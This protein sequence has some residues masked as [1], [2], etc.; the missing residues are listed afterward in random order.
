MSTAR[1]RARVATALAGLLVAALSATPATAS[2]AADPTARHQPTPPHVVG[3]QTVP[4]Y[5]Y[6]DAIR[7][8]VW[9]QT[10]AD[11]DGDGVR[12]RVAV[13]LVRPRE[14]A[15]AGV[16]VPVIM[17]ASPYYLCCGRGNESELKTY[18]SAGVI[19]KAPLFYDNYFVPRGYAFAAVDL[20][21]TAR[22][23][24]CE[25]VGGPAEV[26]SATAVV[27]WLNGRARA[28]DAD[29]RPVS[30]A[31][32]TG[33]VG[34][35]GKSWD[36]SV[37]N[38]AAATGVPGL[39]T[40]VPISAIS[41]WYDY[42]RYNGV[43][44]TTD[45]PGYLHSYVNGRGDDACADVLA[46]LRADSAEETGD[47]NGFWAQRDYRPSAGR[48]R[49]SVFMAHGLNDL[50]VTTNQFAR[51]WQ[52]LAEQGVPRKLWL[53]Q[54][55]HE[56][57]FDV[58]RGAWVSAL[59]RWFDYWLQGLR[60]GVM[61]EPRV[62]LETAPG[63]WTTQRDW[64][65]PGARNV[66]VALGAGDGVTGT[67]GGRGARPGR[68]QAYVD[69]SLTEAELV[70]E[71][72]AA[73]AGRLVFLSGTLT[74][75]LRI[76]GSPSVR[77]RIRVDRPTTE[78]TARLVDYGT[79]ERI[80]YDSSE[81]VRTLDTESCWGASTDVDDACY[82]DTEEITG[83]SDH[84]VLTRGWL[85]AAHHRSLRF[86]TPLRP[87]RWYTV[88]VPLNAYDAVLPAGHVLGLVLGQ[89]DPEF[90][91][92]DDRDATV[93]VDLGRSE[94]VLPVAGRTGL[95]TVTVAP[96]VVTEPAQPSSARTAPRTRQV[97]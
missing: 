16:R 67:L 88:T 25:D 66:R 89:S 58:R 7:E 29:G 6:A 79:A 96:P 15:A 13:D 4:A 95:P 35:I 1:T 90:T 45:Y 5:S 37:A 59:H 34:M 75:P 38:G 68:E 21:G 71:P 2:P 65:A 70:A 94:L 87:D 3:T 85:D 47:R 43:L 32:S 60:N 77:L 30:A 69:E 26:D 22:S 52:E 92:A 55:G 23:T 14:A 48:V 54:A 72:G 63:T 93:R 44:R 56:D 50:N 76:S 51:W 84:A 11:S 80:R 9:V 28:Y 73:T 61:D 20:A 39:A 40:I 19:A 62:D 74:A 33:R 46:R 53:Y 10:R 31:W 27:D 24:G 81:G 83:V 17:D 41:S 36:G 12:D 82:R 49:A 8:S 91:E 78:L 42:M 18:D 86:R 64:P 97:P 57:P